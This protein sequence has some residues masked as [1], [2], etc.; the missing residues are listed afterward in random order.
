MCPFCPKKFNIS[1]G[2]KC[3][4]GFCIFSNL[5]VRLPFNS[6]MFIRELRGSDIF[7]LTYLLF[8]K[9]IETVFHAELA[10]EKVF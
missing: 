10:M 3:I 9:F 5:F 1:L 2:R 4:D 7:K 8:K 6:E